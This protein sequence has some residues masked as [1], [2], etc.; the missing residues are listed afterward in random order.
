[1]KK[2][3]LLLNIALASCLFTTATATNGATITW[4]SGA[5]GNWSNPTNWN[6][7]QVPGPFDTAIITASGNYT[8]TVDSNAAVSTLALGSG[9]TTTQTI[10]LNGQ[11]LAIGQSATVN[12]N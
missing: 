9:D 2:A 11:S 1:M 12:T 10:R 6:P 3:I 7:N 4:A 8:V 5:S